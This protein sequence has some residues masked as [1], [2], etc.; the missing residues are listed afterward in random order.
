MNG[1]RTKILIV[2]DDPFVQGMLS[3]ILESAGYDTTLAD[4]GQ[5]ALERCMCDSTIDLVVSD[6]NMPIMD[7]IQLI[8]EIR[9]HGMEVPIIMV[10]GVSSISVAV[11][12]LSSGAIDYVLKDEGVEETIVITVKRALAK[13]QLKLQNMQLLADLAKK[14]TEQENT[15]SSLTAIIQNMP[16]GLLVTDTHAHIT[17]VNPA[18]GK[19]CGINATSLIGHHCLEVLQGNLAPLAEM[20]AS[21]AD[22]PAAVQLELPNGNTGSAVAAPIRKRYSACGNPD[23]LL[24]SLV[25]IRDVT[26]EKEVERMKN[27]FLST[28]SHE[29]RTPLT[30]V[31]GFTKVIRKKLTEVIFPQLSQDDAKTTRAVQQIVGNMEIIIAEGERLTVLINDVL[32]LSKMEAGKIEWK[33][34]QVCIVDVLE[35]AI[36]A[37]AAIFENKGIP[38]VRD[39]TAG[40]PTVECDRD[41]IVQVLINLLSNAIK[42]TDKGAVTVHVRQGTAADLL[43]ADLA[44]PANP[45]EPHPDL[46]ADLGDFLLVS[47]SDTGVGIAEKDFRNV[48]EKFKQ[49]GDTLTDRPKGSGLGLP[50]CRQIVEY[51]GGRIWVESCMGQGST[52]AFALP[53]HIQHSPPLT[54]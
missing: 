42:F 48:F 40:L 27:D 24:G 50:I 18:L 25:I 22:H 29:L 2:E 6:V 49:V 16:D 44:D 31:L 23:A 7:G 12:A 47:V 21:A 11:D 9:K 8:K 52:F 14:T 3:S 38:I 15:L 41:R 33:F 30:S 26:T 17:L 35:H 32:D 45:A 53:L 51:H 28:V 5:A 46:G 36:A 39:F 4:N 37:T 13:H 43:P 19:M 34:Q 20:A 54:A 10:T 1:L